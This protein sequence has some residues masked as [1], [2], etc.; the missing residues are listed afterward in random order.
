M[1]GAGRPQHRT[2]FGVDV[3][4]STERSNTA[5]AV[6]RRSLYELVD[7]ALHDAGIDAAS[8]DD[9]IDCGDGV[10]VLVH[11]VAE[12]P[13]TVLLDTVAPRL[14]TMLAERNALDPDHR[15]RLRAVL[16]AGEIHFDQRGCFGEALDLAFRLL[17]ATGT[18]RELRAAS[19][20]VVLVASDDIYRG[21]VRHGY[22]GIDAEQFAP[23]VRVRV[24][25]HTH[26]GWI[27]AMS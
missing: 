17:N 16:H 15:L 11:P 23:R 21:V 1:T 20:P 7:A 22:P 5:K 12:A 27:R 18:K 8:R 6:Y 25:G 9:Y 19:G 3:E 4:G 13:K 14:S 24:A 10:M 2:I 26:R